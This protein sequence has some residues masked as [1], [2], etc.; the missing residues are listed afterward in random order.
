LIVASEKKRSGLIDNNV[1]SAMS[2]V[3]DQTDYDHMWVAM[4][5]L[6]AYPPS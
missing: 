3:M 5:T 6:G 4:V 1:L 2:F